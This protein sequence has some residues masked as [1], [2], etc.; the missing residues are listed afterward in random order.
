MDLTIRP[1]TLRGHIAVPPSKSELHRVLICAALADGVTELCCGELC[2]DVS[3]TMRCLQALG[4]A[5]TA[6]ENGLSVK[7]ICT[8]PQSAVFDCGESGSTLR[9]QLPIAAALGVDAQFYLSGRLATRPLEPLLRVLREHGCTVEAGENALHLSGRL[10]PGDYVVDASDSSQFLSGLLLALPLLPGSSVRVAD[11]LS[12]KN[13]VNL[14]RAVIQCFGV[15]VSCADGVYTASGVYHSPGRYAPEGD[16]SAAAY[17]LTA[18]KLGSRI[19]VGGLNDESVQGDRSVSSV[20]KEI[21]EG[22]AV[23]DCADIPDLLPPLAV[24]AAVTPGETRFI[25]AARL[26]GK[27]SD[28]LAAV[29]AMLSALGGDCR[30]TPDGLVIRDAAQLHGASVD[31]CGDHRIA[32]AAAIAATVCSGEVTVRGAE[33]VAKSYPDFWNDYKRLGGDAR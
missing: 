20:L 13:Y 33:C 31:S 28:R 32:M 24:V 19:E 4:T 5:G 30:E 25:H 10:Q 23:V 12:S 22:D 16:W 8:V 14:T 17:W 15:A 18:N 11:E 27:E 26:R 9:F 21:T 7:P 6:I 29:A 3:A 2:D 1:N